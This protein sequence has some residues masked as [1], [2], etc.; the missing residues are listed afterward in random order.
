MNHYMKAT[1]GFM[2]NQQGEQ[3]L[4]VDHKNILEIKSAR[5]TVFGIA[6]NLEY[7]IY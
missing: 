7:L 6:M 4:L 1:I 5:I 3:L 2:L